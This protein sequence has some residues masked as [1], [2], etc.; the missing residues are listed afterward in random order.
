M[1][2]DPEIALSVAHSEAHTT[3]FVMP[4]DANILGNMVGGRLMHHIDLIAAL[5][6]S[7]H[8][9]RI[10]V[11]ASLDRLDFHHPIRIGEVVELAARLVWTGR[12]SMEVEVT[13][14]T[15]NVLTGK[16]QVTNTARLVFVAVDEQ[17]RPT[18]VPP[19]NL[20]TEEERERFAQAAARRGQAR[21]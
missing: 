3:F 19:L 13:V 5:T 12:T 17:G 21:A 10:A 18:P 4:N 15:E 8:S 6:A 11:T 20:E 2:R 16:R 14:Q 7:R 1:A 9:G